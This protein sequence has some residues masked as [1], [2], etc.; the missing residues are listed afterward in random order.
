MHNYQKSISLSPGHVFLHKPSFLMYRS[1][2][3]VIS[4]GVIYGDTTQRYD[5]PVYIQCLL[6]AS[7]MASQN[8]TE[9]A[10]AA[11]GEWLLEHKVVHSITSL[12]LMYVYA[13]W[14]FSI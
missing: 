3:Y 14:I 2:H 10:T 11:R 4:H 12:Y 5:R 8:I 1:L 7:H 13:L 6:M 9:A